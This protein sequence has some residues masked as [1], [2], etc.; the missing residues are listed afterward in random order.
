MPELKRLLVTADLH[1]GLYPAG[2]ASTLEL[3]QFVCASGADAL[4]I[5][6]DVADAD[7]EYFASCL[8]L[9]AG[10]KGLKLVVPGNHDL[11][12][13]GVGTEKKYREV[14]PAIASDC[15]FK[16]LDAGPVAA[17]GV[18]FIGNIG[19]YDYSFRNQGLNVALEQYAL[20]ELPGV[21]TWNDGRYVDWKVS[22]Q[23][24]ADKCLRKLQVAY[25]SIESKVHTA[26][27]V[28]HTV[29]F[30]E[31]LYG[32]SSAAYEF[33]RAYM[34]SERLGR[35]LLDF[36]KLR[37]A[38]CGHRHGPERRRLGH[39]EAFV[40]GSDYLTKRIVDLDLTTGEHKL[41]AFEPSL[42]TAEK[43]KTDLMLPEEP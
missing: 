11:W 6:G 30:R 12:S 7:T 37:Y 41:H 10:F 14:L 15:A 16:M 34:G 19:W 22:D 8:K 3:A 38:F 18:G 42:D 43:R 36:R 27:A 9:F 32:P 17:E 4:A 31:L 33:C 40:V 20:K 39:V 25:R 1:F 23:Q 24:F 2:D 29:P 26:V 28:L 13:A 21:C 35:L 5:A